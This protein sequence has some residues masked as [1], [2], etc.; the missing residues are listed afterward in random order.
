MFM[1]KNSTMAAI[2][3][4]DTN[5]LLSEGLCALLGQTENYCGRAITI[6]DGMSVSLPNGF[7]PD[8]VLIDPAQTALSPTEL[9][10][11][12]SG[13]GDPIALIG[14]AS[15]VD[16]GVAKSCIAAGFRGFLP[17]TT[18][19]ATLRTALDAVT[20]GGVY[21]DAPLA[22][23]FLQMGTG[24]DHRERHAK[25]LTDREQNVLRSV[26]M[27][28]SLKEIGNAMALSAKTIETYKARA[29]SKLNLQGRREIV[30]F[31]IRSGWVQTHA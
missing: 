17:K 22:R 8:M 31:A 25:A 14:Y 10:S 6:M 2:A 28:M 24:S 19:F 20:G 27:G 12:L 21:L 15:S 11:R 9:M 16:M 30:D 5:P 4:F 23:A 29:S 13:P 7:S 26:A 18:T 1:T 3:V